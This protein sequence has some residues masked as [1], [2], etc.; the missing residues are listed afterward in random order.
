MK[1]YNSISINGK[2]DLSKLT[3]LFNSMND[4]QRK[5]IVTFVEGMTFQKSIEK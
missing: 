5:Y 4:E 3:V 2:K 1:S